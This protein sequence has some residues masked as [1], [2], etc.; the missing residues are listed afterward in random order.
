MG[1]GV[2]VGDVVGRGVVVTFSVV[3]GMVVLSGVEL[4][5]SLV[6]AGSGVDFSPG[7]CA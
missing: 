7:S 1:G 5:S 3:L 6:V 4:G 2:V